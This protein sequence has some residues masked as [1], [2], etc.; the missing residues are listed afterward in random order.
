MVVSVI[1]GGD[2][3]LY[4][5]IFKPLPHSSIFRTT[6]PFLR[7]TEYSDAVTL[8]I[9]IFEAFIIAGALL[10]IG[11]FIG[12]FVMYLYQR[13]EKDKFPKIKKS[14]ATSKDNKRYEYHN[15]NEKIESNPVQTG[16][17]SLIWSLL[18]CSTA[19]LLVGPKTHRC[20]NGRQPQI[21]DE[22]A[23][24][25]IGGWSFKSFYCPS[26]FIFLIFRAIVVEDG[27]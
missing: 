5:G 1:E 18:Y 11:F 10:I 7:E 9:T 6:L 20:Y 3:N 26:F 19:Y 13:L 25:Y 22:N 12:S 2:I 14:T 4:E 8:R 21:R 17:V 27:S 15:D 23:I 24:Q 16:K